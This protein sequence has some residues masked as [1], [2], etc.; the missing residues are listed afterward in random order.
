M[1]TSP[2]E[3]LKY[4]VYTGVRP[5]TCASVL[6][7][8]ISLIVYLEFKYCNALCLLAPLAVSQNRIL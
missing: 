5:Y 6:I 7:V 2:K 1:N 4:N 8:R 3:T